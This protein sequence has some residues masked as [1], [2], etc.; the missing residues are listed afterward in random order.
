MSYFGK[1]NKD[2]K[3]SPAF[4]NTSSVFKKTSSLGKTSSF[5][6]TAGGFIGRLKNLSKKDIAMV[7][8]GIG[9][10]AI[11]PVAEHFLSKPTNDN[12][13]TSGFGSREPI[14]SASIYE[15]GI[16]SLS[17][18]SPGGIGDVVTPLSVRDP[19]SLIIGAKKKAPVKAP[20]APPSKYRDTLKDVAKNSFSSASRSAGA[21]VVIPKM[22]G[23]LRSMG[24]FMG[25]GGTRTSGIIPKGSILNSAK[26]ASSKT[27]RRS[28]AGAKAS[29][30]YKGVS[31][32]PK[33][34]SKDTYEQLRNK[35]GR[36]AGHF[37]DGSA[38]TGVDKAAAEAVNIKGAGSRGYG[39]K[40][41]KTKGPSN[42]SIKNSR[43]RSGETLAEMA[44]KQRQQ[45]ALE[46][47]FYKKYDI[48]KQIFELAMTNI[49]GKGV[50]E[51][52]G[53]LAS[54][55]MKKALGL[56]SS[57][58]TLYGCYKCDKENEDGICLKW[59]S[60]RPP[61]TDEQT[62]TNWLN[63]EL[64]D[65][66]R[67][68]SA[69]ESGS[70]TVAETE[71]EVIAD[72]NSDKSFDNIDVYF[73]SAINGAKE[74]QEILNNANF[75]TFRRLKAN[76][77]AIV[78]SLR[79]VQAK[80]IEFADNH[81]IPLSQK[82]S[83]TAGNLAN[84]SDA[85]FQKAVD[86][87]GDMESANSKIEE[88]IPLIVGESKVAEFN[89]IAMECME[90][91]KR[92]AN[93]K[94]QDYKECVNRV[95]G[96]DWD[97]AAGLLMI[98]KYK[99]KH[100]LNRRS[101]SQTIGMYKWKSF[102]K[103]IQMSD[104]EQTMANEKK[105]QLL[106]I[107]LE[108][109]S[110]KIETA[111]ASYNAD[112]SEENLEALRNLLAELS[113]EE[114]TQTTQTASTSLGMDMSKGRWLSAPK[115]MSV[116]TQMRKITGIDAEGEDWRARI[117]KEQDKETEWWKSNNPF[118]DGNLDKEIDQKGVSLVRLRDRALN[119][120]REYE[121]QRVPIENVKQTVGRVKGTADDALS[122]VWNEIC[123]EDEIDGMNVR[124]NYY[125]DKFCGSVAPSNGNSG[126]Q[127]GG[128]NNGS[129]SDNASESDIGE[130]T[131]ECDNFV[132]DYGNAVAAAESNYQRLPEKVNEKDD[133]Y[134]SYKTNADAA[135][136][137]MKD[138]MSETQS[139][140]AELAS[141]GKVTKKRA[142]QIKGRL[143]EL[144]T[145]VK[146]GKKQFDKN[147]PKAVAMAPSGSGT[148]GDN[149]ESLQLRDMKARA[150]KVIKRMDSVY[151]KS[152]NIINSFPTKVMDPKNSATLKSYK[153]SANTEFSNITSLRDSANGY[154][155]TIQRTK[156]YSTAKNYKA[157]LNDVYDAAY[158]SFKAIGNY[159][160]KAIALA[161]KKTKIHEP[162]PNLKFSMNDNREMVLERSQY[163]PKRGVAVYK[164]VHREAG[165][166]Y[167]VL[168][169]NAYTYK[170][171]CSLERDGFYKVSQVERAS[172]AFPSSEDRNVV[173]TLIMKKLLR[174]TDIKVGSYHPIEMFNG[175]SC[176]Q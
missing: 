172:L 146:E 28:A 175:I 9:T 53:E 71:P 11:A 161:G 110:K 133:V 132:A 90:G 44:A 31:S 145:K 164:G 136:T 68:V 74:S 55:S 93:S 73:V 21:P 125:D 100:A 139:L 37:T 34:S 170:V 104:D 39:G 137:D 42:S 16:N 171:I 52:L 69:K 102:Q 49:V 7:V 59:K 144:K 109:Y 96:G 77:D 123:K 118:I 88:A 114:T 117:K 24:S 97:P 70:E 176:H 78:D 120:S 107:D 45:K 165:S 162:S 106:A 127:P 6:K 30:D 85:V 26:K 168:S 5:S 152:T 8:V 84:E 50:F 12:L 134:Q 147:Y 103:T 75:V 159:K 38:V 58:P 135:L 57:P 81:I 76:M 29:A 43:S 126:T 66:V 13:L 62:W 149:Q 51:P 4:L 163:Y 122:M 67:P 3:I 33:G 91:N 22:Q 17:V 115:D 140:K 130:L 98:A 63:K 116:I 10:L 113:K 160:R 95:S 138:A 18:G 92:G 83:D 143:A 61:T 154:N 129:E 23:G 25:S 2:K 14:G 94:G 157:K 64:C 48:K 108:S 79:E 174:M 119:I 35:A 121:K 86:I 156:R 72:E 32:T 141:P 60:I 101:A 124:G 155:G 54:R 15:P 1:K 148:G 150:G 41:D 166:K 87:R 20:A 27:A 173:T 99:A 80:S 128:N 65:D 19:L 169:K 89:E 131:G 142:E 151:L 82:N 112:K 111:L 40:G 47:E 105:E 56:G 158:D 36:S 46:W 167:I 153:T